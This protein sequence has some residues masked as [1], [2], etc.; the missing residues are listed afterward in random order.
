[1]TKPN[2][3]IC[4]ICGKRIRNHGNNPWPIK[5]SGKCCDECNTNI[6]IPA[7][8]DKVLKESK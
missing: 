3:F 7:R 4:C 5:R 2:E 6:V 8:V 1:M